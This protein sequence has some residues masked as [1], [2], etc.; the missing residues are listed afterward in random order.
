VLNDRLVDA[1]GSLQ[2]LALIVGNS[3]PQDVMVA[4]FDHVDR[5]DLHITEMPD[6]G[7]RGRGTH[8]EW[9]WP[10]EALGTKPDPPGLSRGERE[11]RAARFWP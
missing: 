3:G 8:T 5:V 7:G 10:I 6:R 11:R 4:A 1:L 2:M 9:S